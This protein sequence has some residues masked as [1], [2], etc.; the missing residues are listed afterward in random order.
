VNDIRSEFVTGLYRLSAADTKARL[1]AVRKRVHARIDDLKGDSERACALQIGADN[2]DKILLETSR[3]S[4]ER[5]VK[6]LEES[7]REPGAEPP[8]DP[9]PGPR[10]PPQKLLRNP[11]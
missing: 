4:V 2:V 10:L 8:P 6:L 1:I 3:L 11:A 9:R 5:L 7:L